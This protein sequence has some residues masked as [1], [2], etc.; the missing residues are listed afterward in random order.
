[1]IAFHETASP[2]VTRSPRRAIISG[3]AAAALAALAACSPS[4]GPAASPGGAGG[5]PAG[6]AQ[7]TLLNVSYDPTREMFADFNADFEKAYAAQTGGGPIKVNMSHGGSGKQAR[8]VIDGLDADVVTLAL[9]VDIDRIAETTKKIPTNWKSRLP[10]GSAPY[11]STIVLLVRKGNPKNVKDWADLARPGLQ[12]VTPNPKT[13]GGARWNYLA[14]WAW[15]QRTYKDDA[16]VRGYMKAFFKN[17]PVLDT[18]ARGATTTFTQRGIGDVLVTWENEAMLAV[19]ETKGETEIVYPSMSIKAAPPV[20][21]V[22][23]NADRKGTRAAAEA[24]LRRLYTREGQ[25]IVAKHHFRP[26][27]ES[28]VDPALLKQFPNIERVTVEDAFGG[29]T[30]AQAA[31]FDDGASFDQIYGVAK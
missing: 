13:S 2:V 27:D 28:L 3:L 20:T 6:G 21:L 30:K 29:W 12:V 1:M 18:G 31:H 16:K 25:S 15:A 19:E 24:Y 14:A 11:T 26:S 23:G 9:D 4:G 17:V 10:N 22:D 7:I 5:K 8:A